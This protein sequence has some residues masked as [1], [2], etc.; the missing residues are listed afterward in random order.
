MDTELNPNL[1]VSIRARVGWRAGYLLAAFG[2]YM[3]DQV[4]KAWAVKTLRAGADV[5]VIKGFLD[6]VYTEN[7]GIAFGQF[8]VA[9]PLDAGFLS[10]L[11]SGRRSQFSSIC[12]A[13]RGTMIGFWER[14]RSCLP[15]SPET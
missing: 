10:C 14:V 12:C 2:I 6:L 15:E 9:V 1:K 8:Q 13:L 7:P 3:V 5:P 4:T 11:R